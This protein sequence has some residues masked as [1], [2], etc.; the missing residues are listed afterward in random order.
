MKGLKMFCVLQ[1]E[2]DILVREELEEMAEKSDNFSLWYT[3]DRPTEGRCL[4]CCIY[5]NSCTAHPPFLLLPPLLLLLPLP[6]TGWK[7][8]SGFISAEMISD[9]LPSPAATTQILMCGPPPMI[10]YACLPNLEKLGYSKD[11]YVP[12]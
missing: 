8:S 4:H 10:K 5:S 2:Q 3:L 11:M 7:Y 12:F 9:H 6:D 1:T